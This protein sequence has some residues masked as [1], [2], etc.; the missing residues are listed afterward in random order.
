MKNAFQLRL[1]SIYNIIVDKICTV[2]ILAV[3]WNAKI[4]IITSNAST[5]GN[6]K[7]FPS[8]INICTTM[9]LVALGDV[10]CGTILMHINSEKLLRMT[11]MLWLTVGFIFYVYDY[12][13][14]HWSLGDVAVILNVLFSNLLGEFISLPVAVNL[15]SD[16]WKW[17]P[18]MISQHWFR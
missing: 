10:N 18:L 8:N 14:T 9:Y 15:F 6:R 11:F 5:H 2:T 12:V 7:Y 4:C 17:T 16:E 13:L 1:I 3:I